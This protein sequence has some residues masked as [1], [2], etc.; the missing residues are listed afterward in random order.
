[1]VCGY[2]EYKVAWYNPLVGEDLLSEHE[3]GNPCCIISHGQT[4]FFRFL[5][6]NREILAPHETKKR[7]D[8]AT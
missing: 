5:C 7:L 2:H 6:G 3:V 4:A 1:M 8:L